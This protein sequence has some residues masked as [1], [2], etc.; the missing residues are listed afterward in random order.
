[1]SLGLCHCLPPTQHLWGPLERECL[2]TGEET[3]TLTQN[4]LSEA[5]EEACGQNPKGRGQ[6]FPGRSSSVIQT[7][8]AIDGN[9]FSTGKR[10]L[11]FLSPA[12]IL[13]TVYYYR[14]WQQ[15]EWLSQVRRAGRMQQ[16]KMLDGAKEFPSCWEPEELEGKPGPA[17]DL[18]LPR[19]P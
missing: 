3:L 17:L 5:T 11:T 13:A 2:H 6:S 4:Q 19:K 1:M 18:C 10:K 8:G 7:S 16:L 12:S 15:R 14:L 9:R